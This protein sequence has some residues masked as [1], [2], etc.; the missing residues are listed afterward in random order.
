MN[1]ATWN[2]GSG[3]ISEDR[4]N[5]DRENL[6]YVIS[7]LQQAQ[8]DLIF[9]QEVDSSS[10][11]ATDTQAH[12]I[13]HALHFPVVISHPLHPNHLKAGRELS[14]AILSKFPLHTT[15]FHAVPNPHITATGPNGKS[16][17]SF[18]KGFLIATMEYE[19]SLVNVVCGH[20]LP[21]HKFKRN[22]TEEEFSNIRVDIEQTLLS[23]PSRPTIMGVDMNF[24]DLHVLTPALF[25]RFVD[26]FSEDTTPDYGQSDHILLSKDWDIKS[27]AILPGK[28]DHYLCTC[29]CNNM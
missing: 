5:Y 4:T 15:R 7:E 2:I 8:C 25:D 11:N 10:S 19:N 14:I 28:A 26:V 12:T 17:S 27:H 23:L 21:F 29:I 9:L 18:D 22:F 6:S 16:W 24:G 3:F 20:M 1:I 13:A